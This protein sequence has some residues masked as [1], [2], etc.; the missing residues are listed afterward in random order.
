[1]LREGKQVYIYTVCYINLLI[2]YFWFSFI[3]PV[4]S[5]SLTSVISLL[6]ESFAP[7]CLLYAIIAKYITSLNVRFPT[8]QLYTYHL[9]KLLFKSVKRRKGEGNTYLYCLLESYNNQ[10][11]HSPSSHMVWIIICGHLLSA[12]TSSKRP[13]RQACWQQ[14]LFCFCFNFRTSFTFSTE[15]EFCRI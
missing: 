4:D 6:Q 13:V 2:Y 9:I 12:R 14:I 10:Y 8:I 3:Y 1:M 5:S 7:I 15:R 11:W